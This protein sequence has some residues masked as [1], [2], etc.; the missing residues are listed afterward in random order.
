MSWWAVLVEPG[1][2]DPA[3]VAHHLARATGQAVEE[4]AG[5]QV[6]GFLPDPAPAREL[7]RA[8]RAAFGAGLEVRV[9]RVEPV[10]WSDRW[11]EGLEVRRVGRLTVGPSWLLEPGPGRVVVDPEM[12]FGSGEHGS[13]RGALVLL[14][15]HLPPGGRM[16][17]LGSGSGILAIAAAKL[18]ARSAV[19]V[20]VDPEAEPIAVANAER[21]GA[22]AV[23]G[24]LTGD[25]ASLLPL[26]GPVEVIAANI[27]RTVNLT[28]LG[29][30]RDALAPGGVAV[31]AGM[32]PA[33]RELFLEP[34]ARHGLAPVDEVT[35]AGWW[36][37]AARR[38]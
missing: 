23:V 19:G 14:D 36:S 29:A 11:K 31:L 17:D 10:D 25:A 38:P 8:L 16:L 15:R 30:I 27:L 20:E 1:G 13:T 9:E 33:E 12:A 18:G 4:R 6:V 7:T 28:L 22:A 32:E 26:L 37:V 21:N 5:G 3:L 35:D 2:A 34:L 24:F